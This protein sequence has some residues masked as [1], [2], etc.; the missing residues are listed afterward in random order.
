M[1]HYIEKYCT[2]IDENNAIFLSMHNKEKHTAIVKANV[3]HNTKITGST[4]QEEKAIQ[5]K[6]N[7]SYPR[8]RGKA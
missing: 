3:L 8:A 1:A 4:I 7:S 2:K 5:N 6:R